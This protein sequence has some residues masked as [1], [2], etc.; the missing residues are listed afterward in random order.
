MENEQLTLLQTS[1]LVEYLV[2]RQ[3]PNW[4]NN[5]LSRAIAPA[6][7]GGFYKD[8]AGVLSRAIAGYQSELQAKSPEELMELY[9]EEKAKEEQERQEK[10]EWEERQRFFNQPGSA[11]D[12]KHWGKA[13]YWSLEEAIA[14]AFGKNPEAVTW[15]GVQEFTAIS[16]FAKRF[17]QVR[18]LALRAKD[19][20]QLHDHM[21]PGFFLAWAR[22]N[23]VDVPEGLIEQVE[24]Y[25]GVVADWKDAYDRL[26]EQF[27]VI[28]ADRDKLADGC[29]RL[30]RERDE[31]KDK[32]AELDSLAWEGFDPESDTYPPELDM[33]MQAWRAVTNCP[34]P[35]MTPKE[36]IED[37]LNE[38]Y[39]NRRKLSQEARERI[40][41]ICNWE[42]SGGRRR[43]EKK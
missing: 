38:T 3:F 14:L 18:D 21:L 9:R 7:G 13:A 34:D 19:L 36:Q 27:D 37:W 31:L 11:A 29:K 15:K 39:P 32:V 10:T 2:R 33:A 40:A 30:I 26:K 41:V 28:L 20:G 42:K 4:M 12:F 22:R 35:N 16:A 25:G 8:T 1:K 23:G 24:K 5:R 43:S 17:A 6:E